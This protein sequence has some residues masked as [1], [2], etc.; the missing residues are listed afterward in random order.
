MNIF[1]LVSL[2]FCALGYQH[3]I[4]ALIN[5]HPQSNTKLSILINSTLLTFLPYA[6]EYHNNIV[7]S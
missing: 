5:F 7:S 2:L 6:L 3:Q 1:I 4:Q